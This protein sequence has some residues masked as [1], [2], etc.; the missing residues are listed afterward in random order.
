LHPGLLG[1]VP[2]VFGAGILLGLVAWSSGSLIPS[3][4]GHVLM[5]IGL[6]AYWWTG[7]AGDFTALPI[8]DTG[9][10]QP[11][12]IACAAFAIALFIVLFAI[13]KLL[14]RAD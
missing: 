13:S 3:T 1:M 11:F 2:I 5:D 4:L 14:G 8:T 9:A 6:F 10:D 7:I 12:L